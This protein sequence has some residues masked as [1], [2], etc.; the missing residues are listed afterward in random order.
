FNCATRF[1][2]YV[3]GGVGVYVASGGNA[4]I[5][6]IGGPGAAG[7]GGG[8]SQTGFAWQLLAGADYYFTPKFSAFMEYKFLNYQD[9]P[10]NGRIG[11][12]LVGVGLRLHF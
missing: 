8:G 12:Q 9:V 6:G 5:G 7:V 2:P 4:R 1:Q 3:G 10:Q 11:Q